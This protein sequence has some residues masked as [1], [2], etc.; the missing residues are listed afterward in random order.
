MPKNVGRQ[1]IAER[2]HAIISY[3]SSKEKKQQTLPNY[4]IIGLI[5]HPIKRM[6]KVLV[7][8]SRLNIT[9]EELLTEYKK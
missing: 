1:S 9:S 3:I 8:Q 4:T 6:L 7:I 5:I 2:M